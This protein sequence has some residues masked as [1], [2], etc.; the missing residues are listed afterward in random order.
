MAETYRPRSGVRIPMPGGQAD[1]PAGG[2]A[3]NFANPYEARL[4]AEGS[5]V[6][7]EPEANEAADA[8]PAPEPARTET[9]KKRN[10]RGAK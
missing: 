4:V 5:L 10:T 8:A 2:R 9:A 3:V 1:W 7:V 6:K